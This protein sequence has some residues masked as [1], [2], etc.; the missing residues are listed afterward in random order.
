MF[1]FI[2]VKLAS[3]LPLLKWPHQVL[4]LSLPAS[5]TALNFKSIS[6]STSRALLTVDQYL[7]QIRWSSL[8][9]KTLSN[10]KIFEIWN[11]CLIF[12]DSSSCSIGVNILRVLSNNFKSI[13]PSGKAIQFKSGNSIV[14]A[15][16]LPGYAQ[17]VPEGLKVEIRLP[18]DQVRLSND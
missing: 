9:V 11:S 14:V 8:E 18:N 6:M 2:S 13:P 7:M 3:P 17:E 5:V 12:S 4:T 16:A 1:D 15:N 10:K